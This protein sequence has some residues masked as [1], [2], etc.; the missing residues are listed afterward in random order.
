MK[1]H[2]HH[3]G[4]FISIQ[5]VRGSSQYFYQENPDWDFNNQR[6]QYVTTAFQQSDAF[7]N[8]CVW[9]TVGVSG[10]T[11]GGEASYNEMY[12]GLALHGA[13]G[14]T[15]PPAG[16]TS[17]SSTTRRC[18]STTAARNPARPACVRPRREAPARL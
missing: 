5:A 10:A 3:Y 13:R 6:I 2:M 9:N 8:K 11:V 4:K 14:L 7:Y 16:A 17:S 12:A 1:K 18:Q 15:G